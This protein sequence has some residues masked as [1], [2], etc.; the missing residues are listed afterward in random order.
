MGQHRQVLITTDHAL[1]NFIFRGDL[2]ADV[3]NDNASAD[4]F[5]PLVADRRERRGNAKQRFVTR[6]RTQSYASDA[7]PCLY[8]FDRIV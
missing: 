7:A 6:Q 3:S 2:S 4:Q 1:A 8:G 5:S